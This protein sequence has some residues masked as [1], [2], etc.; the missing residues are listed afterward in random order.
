LLT[1]VEFKPRLEKILREVII[2]SEV[3]ELAMEAE[4][5]EASANAASLLNR[6]AVSETTSRDNSRQQLSNRSGLMS[7]TVHWSP[8][9][10]SSGRIDTNHD[11]D[12]DSEG[13]D[14]TSNDDDDDG[15]IRADKSTSSGNH[16][17][18]HIL[19]HWDEPKNV[20]DKVSNSYCTNCFCS[21]D[22]RVD[23]G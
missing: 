11:D 22:A 19:E 8:A 7:S 15:S 20:M 21:I 14:N 16:E 13:D 9:L 12:D 5:L 2:L 18:I 4:I 10:N 1:I 17:L 23:C 6:G 3:A